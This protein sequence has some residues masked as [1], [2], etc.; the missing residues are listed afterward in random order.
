M[1]LTIISYL[2][3]GNQISESNLPAPRLCRG[4]PYDATGNYLLDKSRLIT[5]P[6]MYIEMVI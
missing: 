5:V 6:L 1:T 4:Y 3:S 2:S